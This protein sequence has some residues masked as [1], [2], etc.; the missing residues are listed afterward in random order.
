MNDHVL[1]HGDDLRIPADLSKASERLRLG[2]AGFQGFFAIAAQWNLTDDQER[3]LL[4]LKPEDRLEEIKAHP[5][6]Q[7]FTQERLMRIGCVIGIYRGLHTYFGGEIADAW[8]TRPNL[9]PMYGG[10]SPV[11][12]MIRGGLEAISRVRRQTDA[13]SAGN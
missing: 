6:P 3:Q 10:L 7:F 8:I 9:D 12:Q 11:E 2:P 1:I 5:D 4:D 13:W